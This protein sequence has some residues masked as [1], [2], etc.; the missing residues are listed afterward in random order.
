[1]RNSQK[2]GRSRDLMLTPYLDQKA[3]LA[4]G[5]RLLPRLIVRPHRRLVDLHPRLGHPKNGPPLA[6][7][8]PG[9]SHAGHPR[10]MN[11]RASAASGTSIGSPSPTFASTSPPSPPRAS[12][13]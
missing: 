7:Q 2:R 13:T 3:V 10:P 9:G 8:R 4:H 11:G 12:S 1:M 6:H 5:P